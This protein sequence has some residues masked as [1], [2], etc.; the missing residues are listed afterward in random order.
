MRAGLP[1]YSPNSGIV[2]RRS[3]RSTCIAMPTIPTPNDP[4]ARKSPILG[5]PHSLSDEEAQGITEMILEA[6]GSSR[7]LT[8]PQ[9]DLDE[10]ATTQMAPE[11]QRV[12]AESK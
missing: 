3:R 1:G 11:A 2:D 6:Q 12:L 7:Q 9:E 10:R 5:Q 4:Q 8:I